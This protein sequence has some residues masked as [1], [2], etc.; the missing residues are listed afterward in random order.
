MGV[1]SEVGPFKHIILV[2]FDEQVKRWDSLIHTVDAELHKMLTRLDGWIIVE[3]RKGHHLVAFP[4]KPIDLV[5]VGYIIAVLVSEGFP[6]DLDWYLACTERELFT[7][8]V[9]RK[10][11]EHD[12]CLEAYVEPRNT[13]WKQWSETYMRVARLKPC[14]G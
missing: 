6:V 3:T 13:V 12:L 1:N 2:D 5:K 7:L 4:E 10:Y 14:R 8:R 11:R 9:S